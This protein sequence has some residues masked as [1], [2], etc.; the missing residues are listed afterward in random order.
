VEGCLVDDKYA[1]FVAAG[2]T[3]DGTKDAPFGTIAAGIAAAKSGSKTRVIVCNATYAEKVT[4]TAAQAGVQLYGGFTCP[5]D[6][7]SWAYTADARPLVAPV[8]GTALQIDGVTEHLSVQDIDFKSADATAAGT[9]S[10]AAIVSGSSDVVLKRVAITAGKGADG[11]AGTPGVVGK[12]GDEPTAAMQ[13]SAPACDDTAAL[14]GGNPSTAST[15][16]SLGGVGGQATRADASAGGR[17]LPGG[18]PN[19]GA[20]ATGVGLASPGNDGEPGEAGSD[21]VAG[22]QGASAGLFTAASFTPAT[23]ADGTDGTPGQGGGGGGA[24]KAAG[25]CTGASGGAGGMG[26]CGGTHGGA[27]GGGGASVALLSWDSTVILDTAVLKASAGGNGGVGGSG[28]GSGAGKNGAAGGDPHNEPDTKIGA[29][30]SGKRGGDG[31]SGGSG[32]GGT[33]GPSF[34]VVFHGNA[35]TQSD[36]TALTPDK[37]GAKGAGGKLGATSADDGFDGVADKTHEEK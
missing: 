7:N 20:G 5:S 22:P 2:G 16:L 8:T 25:K 18:T 6:A 37:G 23:G 35:V 27:G 11:A 14:A 36:A 9:S 1:V 10:I 28:G 24:S 30:G 4:I 33:G 3:G 29:G 21:G 17:G 26:G 19:G 15:C 34:A 12:P 13:G 32:S 31:G